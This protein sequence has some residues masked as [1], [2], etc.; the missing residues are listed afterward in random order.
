MFRM[1]KKSNKTMNDPF[2]SVVIITRNREMGLQQCI[3]S[4]LDNTY[5]NIELVIFDNSSSDS[6]KRNEKFLSSLTFKNIKYIKSFPKGFAEM[7]QIAIDNSEGEIIMSIDDDCVA[8]KDAILH[9]TRRFMSDDRIGIVGGDI[10]NVGF[11]GKE[12]FK[13][14]G[15]ITINGKY[16]VVENP[17]E[18]DAFGS[19]NM[20]IRKKAFDE[21]GGYDLF[22]SG[23]LEEVD[24]ALSIKRRGYKV[25]FDPTIKI[26]HFHSPSRFRSKWRNM[27]ILRLY[28]F[29][30]HYTP[31]SFTEWINFFRLELRIL[32]E[33]IE[34]LIPRFRF[35]LEKNYLHDCT[36]IVQNRHKFLKYLKISYNI[37]L[38]FSKILI[39]RII[40][41]YLIY[42]AYKVKK[43]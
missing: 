15:K 20:S 9:I 25:I 34:K 40:I 41:P 18:A 4:I 16:E 1:M 21:V 13:G 8:E 10:T 22:F 38:N 36:N 2:V 6:M 42:K 27:D 14:R 3:E 28:L 35:S 31:S 30:K 33:D 39:A 17:N 12:K 5:K 19:A 43:V 26:T 37:F 24:L 7:R 32:I 11:K 29:F 23:G